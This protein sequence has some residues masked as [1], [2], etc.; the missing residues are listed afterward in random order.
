MQNR[1][2]RNVTVRRH[3]PDIDKEGTV[4]HDCVASF[5]TAIL[6]HVPEN[7]QSIGFHKSKLSFQDL[8]A[9]SNLHERSQTNFVIHLL[10][11][12][13]RQRTNPTTQYNPVLCLWKFSRNVLRR[14]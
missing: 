13:L 3:F 7:V 8:A 2:A 6:T 12:C 14:I 4:N 5:P 11:L 1:F 10:H 9:L